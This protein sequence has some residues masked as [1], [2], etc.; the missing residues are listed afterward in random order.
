MAAKEK[1]QKEI[2]IEKVKEFGADDEKSAEAFE[3][4]FNNIAPPKKRAK[5]SL[6]QDDA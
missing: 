1:S 2:S 3:R 4:A 6:P 5:E